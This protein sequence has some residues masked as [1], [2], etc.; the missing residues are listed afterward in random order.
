MRFAQRRGGVVSL[1]G[2]VRLP[3]SVSGTRHMR[4]HLAGMCGHQHKS[5]ID[6]GN[7]W[8]DMRKIPGHMRGVWTHIRR[9]S[10]RMRRLSVRIRKSLGRFSRMLVG[11]ARCRSTSRVC[12]P[13]RSKPWSTCRACVPVFCACGV[14]FAKSRVGFC[15]GR[16]TSCKTRVT[17]GACWSISAWAG[18]LFADLDRDFEKVDPQTALVQPQPALPAEFREIPPRSTCERRETS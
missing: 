5:L 7:T 2:E 17:F 15:E 6:Q 16:P 8:V 3:R 10:V 1:L 9:M 4:P 12:H 14:A 13:T 18:R 11:G